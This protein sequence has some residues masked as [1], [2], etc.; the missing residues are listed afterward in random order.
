VLILASTSQTRKN[1][2]E[3]AGVPF[4]AAAPNIN[5]PELQAQLAAEPTGKLASSLALAKSMS[6]AQIHPNSI[7]IGVDQTLVIDGKLLHK[8]QNLR[9]AKAQLLALRGKTHTLKSAICCTIGGNIIWRYEDEASLTMRAFSA[10]YLEDYLETAKDDILTSVGAYK[11]EA[12]GIHLFENIEGDYFNILGFP[13]LP[14]LAFLR[15]RGII[16][17]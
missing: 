5:E 1:L 10:E 8:P 16:P 7:I 2:L 3:R 14:L 6:L 4:Q 11:L 17:S 12:T 15:T 9:D 13:L